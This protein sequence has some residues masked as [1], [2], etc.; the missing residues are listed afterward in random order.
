M[1]WIQRLSRSPRSGTLNDDTPLSVDPE[2]SDAK[3][4]DII[5]V[6]NGNAFRS[7]PPSN[8]YDRDPWVI[9]EDWSEGFLKFRDRINLKYPYA[10]LMLFSPLRLR[11]R[12]PT[13]NDAEYFLNCIRVRR[14]AFESRPVLFIAYDTGT[15]LLGW[16]LTQD[17]LKVPREQVLFEAS[18]GVICLGAPK[19]GRLP[20]TK[21]P[22]ARR[23]SF[24]FLLGQ[25][26]DVHFRMLQAT[27][28]FMFTEDPTWQ[29]GPRRPV[30]TCGGVW[31][32]QIDSN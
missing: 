18:F 15:R 12:K 19:Q 25:G 6:D 13:Y 26:E 17:Y 30:S 31:R 24:P 1:S 7:S 21:P 5:A 32:T 8:I 10:R 9:E 2:F 3:Y 29:P 22:S 20:P 11:G 23:P 27:R 4:L 14:A 16:A 28:K